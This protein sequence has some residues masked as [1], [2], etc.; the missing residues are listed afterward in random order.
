MGFHGIGEFKKQK[1]KALEKR[2]ERNPNKQVPQVVS[3]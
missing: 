2:E 3:Y 1:F